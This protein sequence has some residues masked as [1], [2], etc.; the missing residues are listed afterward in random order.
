MY[1]CHLI[2]D[3]FGNMSIMILDHSESF[4][5]RVNTSSS[6]SCQAF[7]RAERLEP[8]GRALSG[9]AF[10]LQLQVGVTRKQVKT[11]LGVH[12]LDLFLVDIIVNSC[13]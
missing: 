11:W 8:S 10:A 5:C 1:Y 3:V 9:V 13:D 6:L 12:R 2:P 4:I 7:R